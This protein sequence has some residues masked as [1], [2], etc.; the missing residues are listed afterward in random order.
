[1]PFEMTPT[2]NALAILTVVLVQAVFLYVLYGAL[3]SLIGRK[4][5]ERLTDD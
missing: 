4:L 5:V 3:E 2:L 1:M